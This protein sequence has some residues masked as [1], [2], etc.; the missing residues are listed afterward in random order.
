MGYRSEVRIMTTKKGFKELNKYVK[1]YLSNLEHDDYN[2]L[3]NLKF[4]AENDY[5]V[6][7]GLSW[8][9]WYGSYQSVEAIE[10]GLNHLKDNEMSYRFARI[11]ENYDDYEE[12]SYE[13]ENEEEQDLEYPSVIREFDDSYVIE[14]MGRV[15]PVKEVEGNEI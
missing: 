4:K 3:D 15:S 7:F 9:K 12:Y 5:A 2:L 14:E 13:S 10:S 1:N 8:I 6:Y 11:G